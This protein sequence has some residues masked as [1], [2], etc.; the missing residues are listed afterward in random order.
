[1]SCITNKDFITEREPTYQL[2]DNKV[3][4]CTTL[5][6]HCWLSICNAIYMLDGKKSHE[7]VNEINLRKQNSTTMLVL[8][9]TVNQYC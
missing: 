1:M 5:L 6:D 7:Y 4:C 9:Y 2:A 8:Y 3:K